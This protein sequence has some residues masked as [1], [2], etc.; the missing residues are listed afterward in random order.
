LAFS[1]FLPLLPLEEPEARLASLPEFFSLPDADTNLG[2]DE[3]EEERREAGEDRREDRELLDE[4]LLRD[5]E[6]AA[7]PDRADR[8]AGLEAR[9]DAADPG[10]LERDRLDLGLLIL[11]DPPKTFSFSPLLPEIPVLIEPIR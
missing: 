10:E 7:E 2:E 8:A 11:D 9:L 6:E 5:L 3:R 4:L 1:F